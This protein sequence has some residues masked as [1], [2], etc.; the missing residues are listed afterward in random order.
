MTS[1]IL[2]IRQKTISKSVVGLMSSMVNNI[3][4]HSSFSVC[5]AAILIGSHTGEAGGT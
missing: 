2:Q 1:R 3:P 4:G 5:D